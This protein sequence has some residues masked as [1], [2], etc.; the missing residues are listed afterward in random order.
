MGGNSA[1]TYFSVKLPFLSGLPK[2]L[3][4]N[5]SLGVDQGFLERGIV[6][7]CFADFIS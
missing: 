6:C 7:I 5:T 2:Q 1:A 4:A 3:K